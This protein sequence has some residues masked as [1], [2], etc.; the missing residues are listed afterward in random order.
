MACYQCNISDNFNKIECSQCNLFIHYTCLYQ[1]GCIPKKWINSNNPSLAVMDILSSVNFI[2]KC[3]S[4]INTPIIINNQTD[5]SNDVTSLKLLNENINEIK[6][7][8]INSQTPSYADILIKS[9]DSIIKT[10]NTINKQLRKIPNTDPQLSIVI[11]NI[12]KQSPSNN[13][14]DELFAIL[15][16]DTSIITSKI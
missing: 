10:N 4:C 3:T 1:A 5:S 14:I 7:L 16:L 12:N 15:E 8:I 2:F 13:I 11:E 6:K 9:T